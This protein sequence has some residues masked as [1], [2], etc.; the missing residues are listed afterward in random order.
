MK[1]RYA[2]TLSLAGAAFGMI[3]SAIA[4]DMT[5]DEIKSF[6]SGK[7]VYLQTTA[8]SAS[9]AAGQVVIYYSA[10]GSGLYKTPSGDIWH[11]KWMTKDNQLCADWKERPNNPCV[12]YV[13][14]G[15]VV[16]VHSSTTNELRA[17]VLK[18]AAGNAENIG[19]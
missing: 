6:I 17:T 19:P 14:N 8:A 11:G 15:D 16:T 18:T 1:L 2:V 5:G 9:G 4:A 12:K 3:G 13:K 7:T 10:E